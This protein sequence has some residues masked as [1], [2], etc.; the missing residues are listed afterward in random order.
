MRHLKAVQGSRVDDGVKFQ[1]LNA[2]WAL[3]SI[4]DG[5]CTDN[6]KA[7]EHLARAYWHVVNA[8]RYINDPRGVWR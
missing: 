5:K 4:A 6:D 8:E 7:L 2:I 3:Q 1:A